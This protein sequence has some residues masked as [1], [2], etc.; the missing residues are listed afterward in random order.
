MESKSFLA[1]NCVKYENPPPKNVMGVN[2]TLQT[3]CFYVY[4]TLTFDPKFI[5]A[6]RN[7]YHPHTI[8][9]HSTKYGPP[10]PKMKDEFT[11]RAVRH[12]LSI[13]DIGL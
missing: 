7:T 8:C 12:I 5:F 13:F 1:K 11:L 10:S 2:I 6:I 4:L 3:V 9:N